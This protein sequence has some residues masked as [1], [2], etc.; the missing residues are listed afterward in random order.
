V[1]V[2]GA[3]LHDLIAALLAAVLS[4]LRLGGFAHKNFRRTRDAT[5]ES[6]FIRKTTSG[7]FNCFE[8]TE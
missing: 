3:C 2:I 1:I 6:F 7:K 8:I 5:G 4:A